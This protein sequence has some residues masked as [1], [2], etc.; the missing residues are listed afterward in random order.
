[1]TKLLSAFLAFQVLLSTMSFSIGAH[2]CG[3][4]LKSV[5]LFGKAKPCEHAAGAEKE[6]SACPFH[7]N[8][9]Q[10]KKDGKGCCDDEQIIVEGQDVETTFSNVE[11]QP[12]MDFVSVFKGFATPSFNISD[13]SFSGYLHYKP[14]I[15]RLDF[16]AFLQTF[17]I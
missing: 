2:F 16:P 11:W 15:L 13:A 9:H 5:A 7:S 4:E 8:P 17:R 3:D 14:P 10:E 1:M 12:A 6:S